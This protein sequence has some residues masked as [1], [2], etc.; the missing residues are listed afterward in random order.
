MLYVGNSTQPG[1]LNS[2][3]LDAQTQDV[4]TPMPARIHAAAAISTVHLLVAVEGGDLYRY[5]TET[6][7]SEFVIDLMSD[8]T[9]LSFDAFSGLVYAGLQSLEV[10]EIQPFTGD[11]TSFETMPSIGRVTVSPNGQLWFVPA[12]FVQNNTISAWDLPDEL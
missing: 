5:N 2:A 4:L 3:D 6:Q 7:E 9:S 11:V 10:L 1:D 12:K 8:V